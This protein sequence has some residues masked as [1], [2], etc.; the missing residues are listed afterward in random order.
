MF[1]CQQPS[2]RSGPSERL[3]PVTAACT[4]VTINSGLS[5]SFPMKGHELAECRGWAPCWPLGHTAG[6]GAA[7]SPLPGSP[8]SWAPRPSI[9]QSTSEGEFPDT[10][11]EAASVL[12]VWSLQSHSG[13]VFLQMSGEW[14][15]GP[16]A[17]GKEEGIRAKYNFYQRES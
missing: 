8:P 1:C 11:G 12:S 4:Q 14:Q 16:V 13:P 5:V 9:S 6:P 3:P 10:P 7:L 2:H 17:W 15:R